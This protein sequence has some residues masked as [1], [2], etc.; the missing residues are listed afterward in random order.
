VVHGDLRLRDAPLSRWPILIHRILYYRL[1]MAL[2]NRI[3]RSPRVN[4]AAVSRLTRESS[5]HFARPDVAIIPNAV[6]LARFTRPNGFAGVTRPQ[7]AAASE[8]EFALLLVG[9]DGKKKAS[10][11]S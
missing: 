4:L 2:E 7:S 6:D 11:L 10:R 1:I 8:N 9:N 5:P 3:Y